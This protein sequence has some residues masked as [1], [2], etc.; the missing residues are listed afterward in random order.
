MG[1]CIH[2]PSR[3]SDLDSKPNYLGGE[4]RCHARNLTHAMGI[5]RAPIAIE[6]RAM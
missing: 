3:G 4:Y 6:S 5:K 2:V 1:D